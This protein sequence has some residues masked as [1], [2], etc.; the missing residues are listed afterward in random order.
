[1]LDLRIIADGQPLSP[2]ELVMKMGRPAAAF[3]IGEQIEALIATLDQLDGDNDIEANGDELDGAMGEDDFKTHNVAWP[4]P[5]CPLADPGEE[6]DDPGGDPNDE[7]EIDEGRLIPAYGIDQRRGPINFGK[8][9]CAY[10]SNIAGE[11]ERTR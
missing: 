2:L 5:G 8:A 9:L 4:M 11:P 3:E 10:L 1:M 6:D 7:G